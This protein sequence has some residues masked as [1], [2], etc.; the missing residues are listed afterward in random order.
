MEVSYTETEE[1]SQAL[2]V[3]NAA[4]NYSCCFQSI[5]VLGENITTPQ[6]NQ[7]AEKN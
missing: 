5:G 3:V 2:L 4:Q 7:L 1:Y 6:V